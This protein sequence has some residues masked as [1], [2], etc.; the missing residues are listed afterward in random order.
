MS[1]QK[2]HRETQTWSDNINPCQKHE[3]VRVDGIQKCLFPL[4]YL[5]KD[6]VE[7]N[8][9]AKKEAIDK[10]YREKLTANMET[11]TRN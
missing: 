9:K 11:K 7:W 10:I 5:I 3:L 4:Y 8:T 1:S 6:I 2:D